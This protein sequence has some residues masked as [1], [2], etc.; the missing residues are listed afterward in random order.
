MLKRLIKRIISATLLVT[1]ILTMMPTQ[2]VWAAEEQQDQI[3]QIND[4]LVDET[5]SPRNDE[6]K[7]EIGLPL[8]QSL[9][10]ASSY[11]ESPGI[12]KVVVSFNDET[13]V[14]D[15]ASLAYQ[16]IESGNI[17]W[18]DATEFIGG[19]VSFEISFGAESPA[20]EYIFSSLKYSVSGKETEVSLADIGLEVKFGVNKEIETKADGYVVDET[21]EKQETELQYSVVSFDE[22]GEQTSELSIPQSIEANSNDI[23]CLTTDLENDEV[24]SRSASNGNLVIA[25]DPGHGGSDP[26]ASGNGL[27]E[28]DLT[29]KI[30]QYCKAELD[31]YAGVTAFLTRAD[32]T[33]VG[34]QDRVNI[35]KYYGADLFVSI[36]INSGA[37][38]AHGVEVYYPN[39]NYNPACSSI[40]GGVATQILNQLVS[41]GL[42]SRGTKIRNS[43]D[44]ETYPDGSVTD[45]YSVIRNSKYAGIPGIIVEHAFLS[46][47]SDATNYLGNE[48]ALQRL[49]K[50]DA[51]GIVNY[52]GLTKNTMS[53]TASSYTIGQNA[54]INYYPT[55]DSTVTLEV[56]RGDNSF[57]KTICEN[58]R[59]SAGSNSLSWNLKDTDGD[60]VPDGTYRFTIRIMDAYGHQTEEHRWFDVTGNSKLDYRWSYMTKKSYTIGENAIEYYALNRKSTVTVDIYKGDNTYL[61]TLTSNRSTGTNDQVVQWDLKGKDGEYVENG[62]YRF[63]ITAVGKDGTKAVSHQWFEVTGNTTFGYRWDYTTQQSYKV[64][65]TA[66]EYYALNRNSTVTV[67]VYKGDNTYLKT[68]TSNRST[69]TNDQVVQ[70]DLKGNDGEYVE[71]GT[72]R[73]TITAVDKKGTK[74]VSHH[75]FDVTGNTT[76]GYRWNYTTKKS[77]KIGETATE[78]YALN[79]NSTVTVEVYKGD[80]TYLKTLTSNRSTGTNDQ[81]VQWDLKGNDGEYVENGTYRF[82]ITAVD[83]KGTKVVSHHWFDVTGNPPFGFK[84]TN[85]NTD[86]VNN[87]SSVS[88]Y[89]AVNRNAKINIEM[90]R[91]DNSYLKTLLNNCSVG[92]NDQ[93]ITWDL[94][95]A[96]GYYVNPGQYRFTITATDKKG[97]RVISHKYFTINYY[98]IMGGTT[99]TVSQMINYYNANGV[100][101][102]YYAGTDAPTLQSFCEMYVDECN[103]EGVRTEV[104]FAQAMKETGFLR[105]GGDVNIAQN[106]FAGI[107]ATGG[108]TAGAS[109]SSVREGIRAQVQH[110]KAY[111]ST[112]VLN[113]AVVDPRFQYVS[114]GCAP[115][116][117]WLGINENPNHK[118]WATAINYGYSVRNDYIMRLLSTR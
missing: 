72:Y 66:T 110:L 63:T 35:A 77:Y 26:G 96:D 101:P 52:Y 12:Q 31:Q 84:W 7:S 69:G 114:R 89:Y 58:K 88:L 24:S 65:E 78:Y 117:E 87:E 74:V 49:G 95:D 56:Y 3:E 37:A 25:I 9:S 113:N 107:G 104:A 62:T 76:F 28:K 86:T 13:M 102:L 55:T 109:F 71:N 83:K 19:A 70:W 53:M 60:Y 8:I 92:T 34:L 116:V 59:V 4:T 103:R 93:V 6:E 16:N 18:C 50:A 38:T 57:L 91:G 44:S 67:E 36:H 51:T 99:T 47:A 94:K 97:T 45:Y 118:G 21:L 22:D 48:G 115:Y 79:R 33:Y 54:T 112:Q 42:T 29:L 98:G 17:E 41:L 15:T 111:A 108:G 100:Y 90:Y 82:T 81:V 5:A 11:I 2:C 10:V 68:L 39:A 32:D 30:A 85:L 61:K 40:G 106:N 105:Y 80:N 27:T 73:F 43:D 20:G 64:G 1:T 23:A 14:M 75:W 46:N